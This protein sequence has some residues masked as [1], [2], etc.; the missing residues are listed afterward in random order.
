MPPSVP[1]NCFQ[2]FMTGRMLPPGASS[3]PKR[4]GFMSTNLASGCGPAQMKPIT[5]LP[6]LSFKALNRRS[7]NG[8]K[9]AV[10]PAAYSSATILTLGLS[11]RAP[12]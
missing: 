5:F 6:D 7:A 10:L 9:S 3:M 12:A 1:A 8:A 2:A 4:S 11:P